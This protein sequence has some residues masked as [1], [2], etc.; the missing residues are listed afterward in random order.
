M[1]HFKLIL[2]AF[3]AVPGLSRAAPVVEFYNSALGHYFMTPDAAEIAGIE[4]GAAGAGWVR[5]GFEFEPL[6]PCTSHS[7]GLC[8]SRPVCRFYGT[9]GVGPNSHF[10]TADPDECRFVHEHDRGWTFEGI[11]FHAYTV[12][13]SSGDCP[14]GTQPVHRAYNN[15]FA[16][17]DSNHRYALNAVTQQRM[18]TRGWIAEGVVFCAARIL[19][20]ALRIF[21]LRADGDRSQSPGATCV[22]EFP[23]LRS[24]VGFN[25]LPVPQ[26]VL[27]PYAPD[28]TAARM[29]A[30]R[31]GLV[32]SLVHAVNGPQPEV[33]AA[34]SFVQLGGTDR[35]GI[36]LSTGPRPPADL[37]SLNPAYQFQLFPPAAGASDDR[38]TPWAVAY[39]TEV[40]IAVEF[41]LRVKRVS[42][43][44]SSHGYGH[45]TLNILDRRSGKHFYFVVLAFG[46]GP[47]AD[48]VM[49]DILTGQ[50]IVATTFGAQTPYGRTFAGS[51]ISTPAG[52][53]SPEAG[54]SGGRF[55]FRIDR[56][57]FQRIVDAVRMLDPALSSSPADYM[58]DD[59]HFNTEVAGDGDIGLNLGAYSVK[60]LRV[61]TGLQIKPRS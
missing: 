46:D 22:E 23:V 8:T 52:Y 53:A 6:G 32:S 37:T 57:E 24:C 21:H 7:G 19:D 10:Y 39:D 2:L 28:S 14:A 58:F 16:A 12:D 42:L 20:T 50:V 45:P 51:L 34:G 29:F 49:P 54:G 9:P 4:R 13:P 5:T 61:E 33:A 44:P 48:F 55:E 1:P 17:N 40:E 56:M 43:S 3:L 41:D 15:R 26:Y 35:F 60:L 30:E 27:G 47:P 25:N 11:A 38:F 36:H 31:T 59:V 18:V